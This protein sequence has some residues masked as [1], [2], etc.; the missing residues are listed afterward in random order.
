[1]TGPSYNS[2]GAGE[3]PK[4]RKS[5][6]PHAAIVVAAIVMPTFI[7][8]AGHTQESDIQQLRALIQQQQA[9]IE[10]LSKKLEA[11]AVS[12]EQTKSAVKQVQITQNNSS[13]ATPAN[14]DAV[15]LKFE[16]SRPTIKSADGN[17]EMALRSTLHF[18]MASYHQDDGTLPSVSPGRDFGS[19]ANF[20][21]A[22]IGIEGKVM[23][24]WGYYANFDFGGSGS[25]GGGIGAGSG[26]IK[27]IFFSYNG[28]KPL[29][30][31]IGALKT[32][33]T[34][35]EST[36]S[37]DVTFI[38]RASSAAMASTFGAGHGRTSV[39]VKA[40][41][42]NLYASAFYTGGVIG[43]G[44]VDEASNLVGRAAY[45]FAPNP[46][47][48]IH[49]GASGT[50]VLAFSHAAGPAAP[51]TTQFNLQDRPEIRVDGTRLVSTG[52]IDADEGYAAGPEFAA[53]WKNLNLQGEY[54]HYQLER[55]DAGPVSLSSFEFDGWYIQSSWILTGEAKKYDMKN[56]RFLSPTPNTPM[57]FGGIGAVEVA[58]RYSAVDLNDGDSSATC[59]GNAG[60]TAP[61]PASS[62]VRGGEQNILTLG[63][64]W[65]PNTNFRFMFNYLFVDADRQA[66]TNNTI[67]NAEIGQELDILAFRSQYSF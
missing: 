17:F 11:L 59:L 40:N 53:R 19:G 26:I 18:D 16:K 36:S 41:T 5:F 29:S 9:Q 56:A 51:S 44:G 62:C 8:T 13:K 67:P 57:G 2:T 52:L 24:D 42:D 34:L 1:M 6:T 66:Y 61:L 45:M 58:A 33:M 30:F 37:N 20:R 54:Y 55:N 48:N 63:L 31:Q 38:E 7:S 15:E 60:Q 35:D 12:S 22:E 4:M 47:T 32:P 10:T 46:D 23:R 50:K 43:E 39:G 65:Y 28:I 49:L 25:E 3:K 64:N 21:R 27:D 14:K